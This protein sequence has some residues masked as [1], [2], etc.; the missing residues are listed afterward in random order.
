VITRRYSWQGQRE[1]VPA[2]TPAGTRRRLRALYARGFDA[3]AIEAESSV[4]AETVEGILGNQAHGHA[5]KATGLKIAAAY[6]R[7]ADLPAVGPPL[8]QA[9]SWAPPAAWD[10]DQL[11]AP[12]GKPAA[13]WRRRPNPKR[14]TAEVAED[15]Q[16]LRTW[17]G[18][19]EAP[20]EVLADRLGMEHMT[21]KR[22][23]ERQREKER[24]VEPERELQLTDMPDL[25]AC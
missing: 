2:P 1:R 5:N 11:D 24:A 23:L 19:S 7:M 22:S 17:G 6:A 16:F 21:L 25:E 10:E 15:V 4:P 18:Y 3:K 13:K 8:P 20:L 12:G 14:T 9:H